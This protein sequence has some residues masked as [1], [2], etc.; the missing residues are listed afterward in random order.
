MKKRIIM[1]LAV[2]FFLN[3][4]WEVAHSVLYDWN[5]SP[6][7]NSVYFFVPKILSATLGDALYIFIMI[8]IISLFSKDFIWLDKPAKAHYLSLIL[9]GLIFTV[10]I[11]L[12]AKY[13]NLWIYLPSMPLIF[14]LGVSPLVQLAITSTLSLFII[15]LTKGE[16]R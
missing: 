3:L 7:I 8:L 14:G 11:E 9:L 13:L 2:S 5:S 12:N 1:F 10:L 15:Q 16:R 6:L 4:F